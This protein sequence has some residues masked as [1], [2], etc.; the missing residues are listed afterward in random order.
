MNWNRTATQRVEEYL[1]AVERHLAHKPEAVRREVVDGLRNQIAET[2]QKLEV[3][4]GEIGLEV[5]NRVL[6]EMDAPETFAEAAAEGIA[7]TAAAV[8]PVVARR[9]TWRWFWLAV[10]FLLVNTYGVWKWTHP[11]PVERPAGGEEPSEPVVYER[12]LRLRKV[13]QMDVSPERELMLTLT[14]S[15]T[16][17]RTQLTRHLHLLADGKEPVE[18]RIAGPIGTNTVVI[19]TGPV[20]TEKL[21]Y[22]LDEGMPAAGDSLPM[23]RAAQGWLTMSM[24]LMVQGVETYVEPFEQPMLFLKLNAMPE[25]N[26][27]RE[28]IHI[29]PA[30]AFTAEASGM[31]YYRGVMIRGDFRPGEIYEVSIQKGLPAVNGSSLPATI[32]RTV[33]IPLPRPAVQI[34]APGAYLSPRS[35]LR[36]PVRAVNVTEFTARMQPV[37]ANNL[38]HLT[39]RGRDGWW[40]Q[41]PTDDLGGSWREQTYM[42]AP[43]RD[44]Q[45]SQGEVDLRQLTDGAP[46]GVY[47]LEVGGPN[48]REDSRLLVVS[49]LGIAARMQ[50]EEGL[51]WVNSLRTTKAVGGATVTLYAKNNQVL[52]TGTTDEQ[53]LARLAWT[54]NED[55]EP[56]LVVAQT[57][58]D[59]TYID[60]AQTVVAQGE[61]LGG[62]NYLQA[63]QVEAAVFSERGV[64]RPG[65]TVFVQALLRDSQMRAPQPFPAILRVRRPDGRVYR[66]LPVEPDAFGA[67]S[68]EVK[69][70]EFLPTGRY[71]LELAMPGT[72]TVLGETSVALEDFVP[73][74]IRVDVQSATERGFVGD[75]ST[76]S[77]KSS[78]LFGRAAAGLKAKGAITFRAA[79]FAPPQ[80]AGWQFGDE[81]KTFKPV[82]RQLGAQTLDEDGAAEFHADS[83]RAWRPP[84]ALEV[85][86]EVT[87]MEASGRSV[88]GYGREQMDAYP[89]YIGMKPAWEGEGMRVGETQRVAI[90][91]VKPDGTTVEKPKPLLVTIQ[92]ATW[93]S[94]LRENQKGRYEWVSERQVVEVQRDTV[95]LAG[96][97]TEWA[98]AVDAPG[99]YMLVAEDPQSGAA[100][101]IS[102][103]AG[104]AEQSWQAWSREKPGRVEL[105]LD[106][107]SYQPGDVARLQV[108]APFAGR[109][110]LTVEANGVI[111]ART[112][113]L[114]KNT[115]EFDVPIQAAY[116]P[117]VYCTF[118]LI[119]PVVEEEVWGVHRAIGAVAVP[120]ARPGR[121]LQMELSAPAVARPQAT[122]SATVTVRA[123]DG[124]P[125]QG[126]VTVMAVDE[127][128]CML[129]AFETPDPAQAFMAQ[130]ALGMTA[131]DLYA[132]LMPVVLRTTESTAAPG[133]DGESL[134]RRR[135]NP[136]KANRFKPV[137]LWQAAVPLDTN[138]QAEVQFDVPEFA[139]E[140]RLMAVAY[141]A[142]QTGVAAQPVKVKRD[143]I[144]QP[145]L[146]RFLAIGD[147]SDASVTLMNESG[148]ELRPTVRVMCGGPL[149]VETAEQTA[150]IPA[151]GTA[152]LPMPLVAG[153]GAGKALCTIEVAAG[154][155]SYRETIELPVRPA[156]GTQVQTFFQ[157]V[158]PGEVTVI[159]PPTNWLAES[160]S[161]GGTLAG[162]PSVELAGAMDYVVH[163]PYGCL[164][165]TISGALPLLRAD[166]LFRRLPARRTAQG[167]AA[168]MV[169][170]AIARTLSMQRDSGAFA[171]WP[172]ENAEAEDA[173][174]YA[175]HFL[176]EARAAGFDVA[177]ER[178]DAAMNWA[179]GRLATSVRGDI[180][181]SEWHRDLQIRAY[182]CHVL[183]LANKPDVGW[184]ARLRELSPRLN[185][186]TKTHVAAAL[187]LSGEPRQAV[188]L[189]DSLPMPTPGPRDAGEWLDSDVRAAA[190][191]LATWLEVDPQN[192]AVAKLAQYLR[193]RQRD[194]HWGTTQDNAMALLALGKMAQQLPDAEEPLKGRI[195]FP[196]GK[197]RKF[198]KTNEVT[199]ALAE[200]SGGGVTISNAGAG[201]IYVWSRCEGVG[202]TAEPP[203]SQGVSL[204][205]EYLNADGEAINPAELTQG[206]LMVVKLTVNPLGRWMDHLILEDLLPAGWEIENPNLVTSKQIA[207]LKE[208]ESDRYRDARD[209]R[210][211]IFTA[212]IREPAAFHYAVRVVTPG[213]YI[214]PPAMV[215]GMYEPEIRAVTSGGEVRVVP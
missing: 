192:A 138:G 213:A 102:F 67:V 129:T 16:P 68:A 60:L 151:G 58:D 89:F 77:V 154:S 153:P 47:W 214:Q 10:A 126:A 148:A 136:I 94:V 163:Y 44:G 81:E 176:T 118:T 73:P 140:L 6:A 209:D 76:F 150:V 208:E 215:S 206:D 142:E 24:N 165:Q 21:Q 97:E 26:G 186:V 185:D 172:F 167:D 55:A 183:A 181:S 161:M 8:V 92:R 200:G 117:N 32:Q 212:P 182:I 51:V 199:W 66:D 19:E 103:Y 201:K 101:R 50:P 7:A 30:V 113:E 178:Y 112:V 36:V 106:K 96:E 82:Y 28:F 57:D 11:E 184:T 43:G 79:P 144:V 203:T 2:L 27:L 13:E 5:V 115:A 48:V 71:S 104:S 204:Q 187:L 190:L 160:V 86:Q 75:V 54:A 49:D 137:A 53:G 152:H 90:A 157:E 119:R 70:P 114:K 134:L 156:A 87:V 135:L 170:A 120:V 83:R 125:A 9:G 108:R 143:L 111:E 205:R 109:A 29:E 124:Q 146:P 3:A 65:E 74:Q 164:E 149:R 110:L 45:P 133:G 56:F 100:T 12:V 147:Y 131:H 4:G 88:T 99:V 198:S 179:R 130:R 196:N 52:S 132:A 59:L 194:G 84:A 121:D 158:L 195:L 139:G 169:A 155:E 69:L 127:A 145:S 141:N 85:V 42:L 15:E 105:T 207:W 95:A 98:F 14:F 39:L 61:G 197:S 23:D 180:E 37:F 31:W 72:F 107:A 62:K 64:Y 63:D 210:M 174:V 177:L 78:Y 188:A 38:V 46:K 171:Y 168:A 18:Y 93:N 33:Q 175:L 128:I 34:H 25:A 166:D 17:D 193:A 80:W 91:A 122:L 22:V 162:T 20:L 35:S 202:I 123:A 173:S 41:R 116:A 191:L 1:A 40:W 189:L 159:S 211:L